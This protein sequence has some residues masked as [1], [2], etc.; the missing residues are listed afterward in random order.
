V[1]LAQAKEARTEADAELDAVLAQRVLVSLST[2]FDIM[3]RL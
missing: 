2:E 3:A 1:L